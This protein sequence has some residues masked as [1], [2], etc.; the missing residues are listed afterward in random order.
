MQKVLKP[1]IPV[2]AIPRSI[3]KLTRVQDILGYIESGYVMLRDGAPWVRDFI[4]E[5][6]AFTADDAHDYDDQIDPMCDAISDMLNNVA[7]E[8]Q[9]N[10]RFA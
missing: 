2:N 10:T 3:D 6:E 4:A 5:C 9:E 1:K 7:F 8:W